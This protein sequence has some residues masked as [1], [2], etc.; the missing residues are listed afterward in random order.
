MTLKCSESKYYKTALKAQEQALALA[1]KIDK[2]ERTFETID[3]I[4]KIKGIRHFLELA[5]KGISSALY[6]EELK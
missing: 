5:D 1:R 2:K 4:V 6:E 3:L